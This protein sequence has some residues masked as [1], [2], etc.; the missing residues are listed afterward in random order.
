MRTG[1]DLTV[2]SRAYGR[3][4]LALRPYLVPACVLHAYY[5]ERFPNGMPAWIATLTSPHTKSGTIGMT[6]FLDDVVE[7]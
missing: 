1:R 6:I 7:E 5:A 4:V 3:T 2:G